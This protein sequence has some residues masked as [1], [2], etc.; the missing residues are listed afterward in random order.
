MG[1]RNASG[2]LLPSDNG[3][4][5]LK[6]RVRWRETFGHVQR[7]LVRCLVGGG[8][9]ELAGSCRRRPDKPYRGYR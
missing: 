5:E 8:E 3:L 1:N 4:L 9:E 2:R 6:A 7:C